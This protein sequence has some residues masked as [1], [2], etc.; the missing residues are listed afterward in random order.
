M[1]PLYT[2]CYLFKG[3]DPA[4]IDPPDSLSVESADV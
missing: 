3:G 2:G 4:I 1:L